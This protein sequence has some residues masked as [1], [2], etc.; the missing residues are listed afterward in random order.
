MMRLFVS[1]LTALLFLIALFGIGLGVDV[2]VHA[3]K[4]ASDEVGPNRN[5]GVMAALLE[6]SVPFLIGTVAL[7]G[8]AISCAVLYTGDRRQ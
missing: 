4:V 8:V 2:V 6:A 7:T 1:F 5:V 3:L